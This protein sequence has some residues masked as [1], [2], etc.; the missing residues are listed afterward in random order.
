RIRLEGDVWWVDRTGGGVGLKGNF[1]AGGVG[2]DSNAQQVHAGQ[3]IRIVGDTE[4]N[5]RGRG[6][7]L[8]GR[9]PIVGNK[10]RQGG[11]GKTGAIYLNAGRHPL[12]LEWFNGVERYELAVQ[13]QGPGLSR[14]SVPDSAFFRSAPVESFSNFVAGLDYSSYAVDGEALP[15]FRQLS[16]L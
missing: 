14:Q 8:R 9:G 11:T 15:D 16:P 12:R 4:I 10:G 2:M 13:Y 5:K 7:Q 1:G 6:V 3:R